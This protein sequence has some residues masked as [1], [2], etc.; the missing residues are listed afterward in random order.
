VLVRGAVVDRE[1]DAAVDV[2]LLQKSKALPVAM[3]RE[4]LGE[5]LASAMSSAANNLV[6]PR[7][8]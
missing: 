7:R 3:A 5:D 1:A 8:R 6:A 4:R 2:A